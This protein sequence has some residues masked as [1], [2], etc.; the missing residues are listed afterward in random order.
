MLSEVMLCIV[1]DLRKLDIFDGPFCCL[2][3]KISY[4]LD[5][6]PNNYARRSKTL[7]MFLLLSYLIANYIWES[8]IYTNFYITSYNLFANYSILVSILCEN[9]LSTT[10]LR[11]AFYSKSFILF[12]QTAVQHS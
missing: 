3:Y 5:C 11:Q 2:I 4:Y 9:Y 12:L 6:S 8:S 7:T 10:F 1:M